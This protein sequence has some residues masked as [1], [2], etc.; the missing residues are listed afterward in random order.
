MIKMGTWGSEGATVSFDTTCHRQMFLLRVLDF[1]KE[2][3][4]TP[5]TGRREFSCLEFLLEAAKNCAFDE[6]D[7]GKHLAEPAEAL[8]SWLN[9]RQRVSLWLPT[10]DVQAHLEVSRI[11]F[12]YIAGNQS[13]HNLSRLTRVSAKVGSLLRDHGYRVPDSYIPLALEDFR[14]H[15][16]EDYFL[17][18]ATW[19]AQML[20]DVRWGIQ[21]YIKPLYDACYQATGPGPSG[22][23]GYR[24]T[25]P[26]DVK[27]DVARQWFWRL[28]NNIRSKP[29]LARFKAAAR[30]KLQSGPELR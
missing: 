23:P 3:G 6:H 24:Y 10:L 15:L 29:K 25:Y 17:Y 19:L 13:K 30:L 7:S 20:N 16:E 21:S 4:G 2:K 9:C 26:E 27:D 22:H 1:C 8:S 5:F 28:M 18:Y 14:C 11:D 12:L